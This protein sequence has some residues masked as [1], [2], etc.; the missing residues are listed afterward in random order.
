VCLT[1]DFAIIC[2]QVPNVKHFLKKDFWAFLD[3]NFSVFGPALQ[4]MVEY[5]IKIRKEL[6]LEWR[7]TFNENRNGL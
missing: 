2:D 3:W 5:G 1:D 4:M 7:F 6:K